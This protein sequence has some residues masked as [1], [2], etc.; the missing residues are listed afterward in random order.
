MQS[1]RALALS[2]LCAAALVLA[3]D[4]GAQSGPVAAEGGGIAL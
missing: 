2:F 3:P 4:S 1:V